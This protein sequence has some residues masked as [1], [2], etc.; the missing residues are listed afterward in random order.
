[1]VISAQH[2]MSSLPNHFPFSY[3]YSSPTP[4]DQIKKPD[5][6][7][8][9][10]SLVSANPLRLFRQDSRS[11]RQQRTV[12]SDVWPINLKWVS[13]LP[14]LSSFSKLEQWG[15]RFPANSVTADDGWFPFSDSWTPVSLFLV[16]L[17]LIS[18]IWVSWKRG[19][20]GFVY[21]LGFGENH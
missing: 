4:H 12:A 3:P 5:T 17:P 13:L 19:R 16:V 14:F 8:L 2:T 15:L 1:M 9:S 20:L 21:G 6:S 11:R 10:S 18:L 7:L